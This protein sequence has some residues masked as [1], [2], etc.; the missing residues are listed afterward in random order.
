[1]HTL[2]TQDL[3]ALTARL[4]RPPNTLEHALAAT[5]YSEHCSY[6]SSKELLKTFGAD[7]RGSGGVVD[8][9]GGLGAAFKIESHNHP[10][11]LNPY[12]GAATGLGG[13]QRDILS[14]G[15]KPLACFALL[16]CPD[17]GAHYQEAL[18]GFN[19]YAH[20][21]HTQNLGCE[22]GFSVGFTHNVVVN[23][24]CVGLVLLEHK[25][26][27]HAKAGGAFVLLGR[28]AEGVGVDGACMSSQELNAH[29]TQSN[30]PTGDP[31][32]Q[33]KLIDACLEIYTQIGVLG[34]QDLG[35]GGLGVACVEMAMRGGVG[36][37]LELDKV[38]CAK[39][40]EPMEILLNETQERMLLCISPQNLEKVLQTAAK[41][42]LNAHALGTATI[43]PIFK[44]LYANQELAHLP[45][46]LTP[47]PTPL[48][49][50]QDLSLTSPLVELT[51]L[52]PAKIWLPQIQ[53]HLCIALASS[54]PSAL[55]EPKED[56]KNVCY[57]AYQQL[58]DMGAK[59]LSFSDSINL[60]A[61]DQH[62]AW[63]LSQMCLG[64]KET[65]QELGVPFISGN[66]SLNNATSGAN[67]IPPTL[68]IVAVGVI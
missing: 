5:L 3:Q 44:A 52:P 68:A 6:R 11:F 54:T 57:R 23:A 42:G 27:A 61:M 40:L 20:H 34:A 33:A 39:K 24:F 64:L 31:Q 59:V 41:H 1:M 22:S 8:L 26:Q 7:L 50:K 16:R 65:H 45:L 62:G 58:Q 67:S 25:V 56:S 47:P 32:T 55:Q 9:G 18:E 15:A 36:A 4:K 66:V 14:L 63:V 17:T 43:E 60:G 37:V 10:S 51:S 35:A 19:A 13:V 29:S 28:A 48:N 2:S 21:T 38:P 53:K 12:A 46:P 30:I 49:P